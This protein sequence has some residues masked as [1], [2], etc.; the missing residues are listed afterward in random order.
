MKTKKRILVTGGKGL[1]GSAIEAVSLEYQ[2][3][4]FL[5]LG[6]ST[7]EEKFI[8]DNDTWTEKLEKKFIKDGKDIEVVNA[9][10]DGQSTIGHIYN[11][12]KWFPH[13]KNLNPKFII[14][15]KSSIKCCSIFNL[16][17]T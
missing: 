14:F 17:T 1:V 5:V 10:I 9:G 11:F 12:E 8:D 6:G 7:T 3:I 13:I 16:Y 4:D 15:Y 2:N